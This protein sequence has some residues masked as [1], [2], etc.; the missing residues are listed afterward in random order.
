MDSLKF[1]PGLPCPAFPRPVRRLPLK[2]GVGIGV[3][4]PQSGWLAAIFYT[5]GHPSPYAYGPETR[6][7]RDHV[8]QGIE[9][10]QNRRKI[11]V[12]GFAL[13]L[14]TESMMVGS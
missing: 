9:T 13:Y 8:V 11:T 2:L 14:G 6:A 5:L 1:H 3:A 10:D 12:M 4:R 7:W